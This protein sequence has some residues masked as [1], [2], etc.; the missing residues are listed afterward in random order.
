MMFPSKTIAATEIEY[1]VSC[2]QYDDDQEWF[3]GSS[4]EEEYE[5]EMLTNVEQYNLR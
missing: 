2:L 1:I 3:A 5:E 4:D